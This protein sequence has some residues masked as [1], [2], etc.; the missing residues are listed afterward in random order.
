M[1][2]PTEEPKSRLGGKKEKKRKRG[3]GELRKQSERN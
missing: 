2:G 1:Y 3:K